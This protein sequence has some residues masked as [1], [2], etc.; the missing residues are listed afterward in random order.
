[1]LTTPLKVAIVGRNMSEEYHTFIK[2]QSLYCCAVAGINIVSFLLCSHEYATE[3]YRVARILQKSRSH[4]NI[5]GARWVPRSKFLIEDPLSIRDHRRKSRRL[6]Y[7]ATWFGAPLEYYE[8]L[9]E[10]SPYPHIAFI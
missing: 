10:C 2:R 5:L 1:M 4:L 6:G 9:V 7:P 8:E 3:Y